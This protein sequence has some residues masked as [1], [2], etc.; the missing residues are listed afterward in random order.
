MLVHIIKGGLKYISILLVRI[1]AGIVVGLLWAYAIAYI[2]H[3]AAVGSVTN[4]DV[5][6]R[7]YDFDPPRDERY[8][9]TAGKIYPYIWPIG[10]TGGYLF[11][12]LGFI[13][14]LSQVILDFRRWFR[15]RHS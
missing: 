12:A 7:F 10:S 9:G 1:I 6:D 3:F 11:F 2:F 8:Y 15:R 4:V 13:W 14:G 5:I